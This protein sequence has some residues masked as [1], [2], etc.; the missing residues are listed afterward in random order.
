MT[1]ITFVNKTAWL[2]AEDWIQ[3]NVTSL[4]GGSHLNLVETKAPESSGKKTDL[5]VW[6]T[7]VFYRDMFNG[8]LGPISW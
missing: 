5:V 4:N 3:M 1:N 7:L 6:H 8:I 2:D